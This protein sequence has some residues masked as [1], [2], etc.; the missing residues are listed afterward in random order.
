MFCIYSSIHYANK[1][2][3]VKHNFYSKNSC[4]S[5]YHFLIYTKFKIWECGCERRLVA[6]I[7]L[8][9]AT[10]RKQLLPLY[11]LLI[12]S[13]GRVFEHHKSCMEHK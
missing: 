2:K 5:K 1:S 11:I 7:R 6:Y 3:N 10:Q 13:S 8:H 12:V 9:F 4:I